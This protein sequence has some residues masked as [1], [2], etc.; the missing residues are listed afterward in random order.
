MILVQGISTRML[1]LDRK[2]AFAVLPDIS[3]WCPGI[4]ASIITEGRQEPPFFVPH[5]DLNTW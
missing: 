5:A 1:E 4:N 2:G 3:P